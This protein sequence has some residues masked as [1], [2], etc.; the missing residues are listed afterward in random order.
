VGAVASATTP[1]ELKQPLQ[2]LLTNVNTNLPYVPLFT[3]DVATAIGNDFV[4]DGGYSYFAIGQAW[5]MKI[6]GA[7]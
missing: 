6:S 2:D 3:E 4:W 5:P 1:E 7:Q